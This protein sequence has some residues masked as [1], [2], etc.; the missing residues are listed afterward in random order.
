M[1]KTIAKQSLWASVVSYLG[2]F[3]G[4]LTTFFVMTRYLSVEEVGLLRLI[5]EVASLI[6]SLAL[7]G[8][9]TSIYRF[10]PLFEDNEEQRRRGV[11]HHGFFY[12]IMVVATSGFMIF[13]ICYLLCS[14]L[15]IYIFQKNSPLFIRY[16]YAVLPLTLG[17]VFWQVFE[18]YAI[19]LMKLV[20]PKFIREMLLR[21]LL[22]C[23][24]LVY[25]LGWVSF[26][27]LVYCYVGSYLLCML[28]A[29]CYLGKLIPLNF[30]RDS[31]ILSPQLRR[32]F[33]RYTTYYTLGSLGAILATRMDT[34]MLSA[35]DREGLTST[36]IFTIA[37][38][39]VAIME[40]PSRAII[41]ISSPPLAKAMHCPDYKERAEA[42]YRNVS[43]YQLILAILIF[44][45]IYT[46]IDQIYRIMPNG[47]DYSA[48]KTIFLYLA[49]AKI[50]E[51]TFNFGLSIVSCSRY[52]H[53]SLYYTLGAAV[54]AFGC[55]YL[56]IPF[57][58]AD[59]AALATLFVM[60]LSYA[61]LQF[62]IS[63]KL[64]LSPF[65]RSL[66]KLFLWS[67]LLFAV[68]LAVPKFSD[69]PFLAISLKSCVAV[70]LY[71]LLLYFTKVS[72]EGNS[73][74]E[75]KLRSYLKK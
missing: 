15:F 24:Y 60:L 75:R 11:V 32:E 8:L 41:S 12:Y 54:L 45:L 72:P 10:Y 17:L 53:W 74:I 42:I 1:D 20:V 30:K 49:L 43:L 38:F 69:Q 19:Q 67:S 7:M 62:F 9:N 37:F 31:S 36:G 13:G 48:G 35:M 28:A 57:L 23:S 34:F 21:V 61:V 26:T 6:G 22:L 58:G 68:L 33:L 14:D 39:M 2:A 63:K 59:G 55:N 40:M 73:L 47:M 4:F 3:L 18:L 66:G 50:V 46:N 25:A 65:S 5:L 71:L 27:G 70:A 52:Y 29:A 51:L 64:G 44:I 16:Y 56:L